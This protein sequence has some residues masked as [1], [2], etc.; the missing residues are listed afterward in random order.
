MMEQ[1]SAGMIASPVIFV[2]REIQFD[3]IEIIAA[4]SQKFQMGFIVHLRAKH[5]A[6]PLHY[7]TYRPPGLP[8]CARFFIEY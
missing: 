3:G 1:T 2:R 5:W 6:T 4:N 7:S 8:Q